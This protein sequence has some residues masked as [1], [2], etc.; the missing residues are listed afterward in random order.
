MFD[1]YE[2]NFEVKIRQ[3]VGQICENHKKQRC[4]VFLLQRRLTQRMF[5]P[6]LVKVL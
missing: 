2:I 5:P 1:F 4:L 6:G 3:N